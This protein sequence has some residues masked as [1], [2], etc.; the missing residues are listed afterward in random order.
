MTVI[1]G[2][3]GGWSPV[4]DG[5][6]LTADP[7]VGHHLPWLC[8]STALVTETALDVSKALLEARHV[9]PDVKVVVG[10]TR[11]EGAYFGWYT[12]HR[13]TLTPWSFCSHPL[14]AIELNSSPPQLVPARTTNFCNRNFVIRDASVD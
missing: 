7:L 3:M 9:A 4:V 14:K 10:S 2:G 13:H 11:D 12:L 1:Q 8:F 5:V 6:F